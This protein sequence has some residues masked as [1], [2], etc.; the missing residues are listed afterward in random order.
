MKNP[1]AEGR[2]YRDNPLRL[3]GIGQGPGD[4]QTLVDQFELELEAGL[5][6]VPDRELQPGDVRG[7]AAPLQSPLLRLAFDLMLTEPPE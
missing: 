4:V 5:Q 3:L 2:P 6:P 1:Y 7:L